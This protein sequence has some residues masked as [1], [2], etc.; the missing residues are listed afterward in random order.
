M[1]D[2]DVE[3]AQKLLAAPGLEPQLKAKLEQ[4]IA[5]A[6]PAAAP[7]AETES[8]LAQYQR[9][10]LR[11]HRTV[12][13]GEGV[14]ASLERP[15][16]HV[17]LQERTPTADVPGV[18][19]SLYDGPSKEKNPV[20]YAKAF[21]QA[22]AE[23]R[24][25]RSPQGPLERMAARIAQFTQGAQAG[26]NR[27][28]SAGLDQE[29]PQEARDRANNPIAAMAGGVG[30]ALIPG[31]APR[32]AVRGLG[33]LPAAKGAMGRIAQEAGKGAVGAAALGGLEDAADTHYGRDSA[34]RGMGDVLSRMKMRAALGAGI[35]GG[36]QALGE[37]GNALT[38]SLRR[39]NP[40]VR[41]LEEAGGSLGLTGV[42]E[43]PSVKAARDAEAAGGPR[44]S[45][46]AT[47]RGTAIALNAQGKKASDTYARIASNKDAYDATA[48]GQGTISSEPLH[49]KMAE[50]SNA[51]TIPGKVGESPARIPF[52]N[53]AIEREVDNLMH[54]EAIPLDD[55]RLDAL[56]DGAKTMSLKHARR[57]KVDL[58]DGATD[59][60][61]VLVGRHADLTSEQLD[62]VLDRID[63][64][65]K[66]GKVKDARELGDVRAMGAVAR[67]MREQFGGN[68]V[69]PQGLGAMQGQHSQELKSL[70]NRFAALGL[71][72]LREIDPADATQ[73]ASVFKALRAY[74]QPGNKPFDDVIDEIAA[75]NPGLAEALKDQ[76]AMRAYTKLSSR[77]PESMLAV[78]GAGKPRM[79][80]FPGRLALDPVTRAAAKLRGHG[81]RVGARVG[82]VVDPVLGAFGRKKDE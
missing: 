42:N 24:P 41:E 78:S 62:R 35:G 82:P 29:S 44:A 4:R 36:A 80:L 50:L 68:E 10:Y 3:A 38:Q 58:P 7:A 45:D 71:G 34:P 75:E 43:P 63:A 74:K 27:T 21:D 72:S 25:F 11:Q 8:P 60:T 66:E 6:K 18:A 57:L 65:A 54:Y 64:A 53:K 76:G 20:A 30:A 69:A 70:E 79:S 9:E 2:F 37:G 59:E 26:A 56:D 22:A 81:G 51:N 12:V 13:P 39:N 46:A 17:P 28:L 14:K 49:R 1:P 16:A 77:E 67:Q 15:D 33:L 47:E 61:H 55:A 40:A 31:G 19:G 52:S 73:R 23:G 5:A 32:L 48:E